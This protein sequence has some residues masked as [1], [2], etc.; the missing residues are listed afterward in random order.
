MQSE[1]AAMRGLAFLDVGGVET[2]DVS[3]DRVPAVAGGDT[4]PKRQL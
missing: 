2:F 4:S 3:K 1:P